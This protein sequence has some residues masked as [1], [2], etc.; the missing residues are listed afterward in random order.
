MRR[1]IIRLLNNG[2]KLL[3]I[4]VLLSLWEG[5][6]LLFPPVIL[7]SAESIFSSLGHL[8]LSGELWENLGYTGMRVL[9]GFGLSLAI[10]GGLG[11]LA[12]LVKGVYELIRPVIVVTENVPPIAWV[13]VA[14]IW[15]GLGSI[16]PIFAIM[17]IVVPIITVNL[18]QGIRDLDPSLLEMARAFE[19]GRW[20]RLRD[21][22]LP[23][24]TGYIFSAISVGLG[25]T[26]RVVV[27]AEFFGSMSGI[28]NELNWARF[29]IETDK[30]FAYTLIIVILGLGTEYLIVNPLKG[31]AT[32]WQRT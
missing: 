31:W 20:I 15:F 3:G 2:Y 11:V 21:F 28:G 14:I 24:I 10:G 17:S 29:N 16:P 6:S 32:R 23:A 26:W 18:A 13:I 25:L 27:M 30:A 8:A 9:V 22:Y 1:S 7:P 19:V 5:L 12:G 4:V